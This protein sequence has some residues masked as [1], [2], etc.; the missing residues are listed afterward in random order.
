MKKIDAKADLGNGHPNW[1]GHLVLSHAML[2]AFG[3]DPMP[4]LGNFDL[5][6][7]KGDN[8]KLDA[9]D[10]GKITLET[11]TPA[12]VPFW[13]DPTDPMAAQVMQV[14]GFLDIAGQKLTVAGLP[15]TKYDLAVDGV[16]VADYTATDLAAGVMIPGSYS[17]RGKQLHDAIYR[18]GN[19]YFSAWR[20]I[21]VCGL[22]AG[23]AT[24]LPNA[25]QLYQAMMGVD[26]AM[27]AS[28][29][30]LCIPTAPAKITLTPVTDAK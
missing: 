17:P 19:N 3:A 22:Y 24:D 12:L 16:H 25:G 10:N 23:W 11:T 15:G 9:N 30:Q 26:D 28:I 8:L 20:E 6:A 18:K 2:Q 5:T 4:A 13:F 27:T 14:S 29:Q 21:R 1:D 7:N